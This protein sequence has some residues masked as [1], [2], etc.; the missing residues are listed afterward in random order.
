VLIEGLFDGEI[1]A[2]ETVLVER[3]SQAQGQFQANNVIVSGSFDGQV[4]CQNRFRVT[5]TGR[6]KGEVNTSILVVEEGSTVNCRFVMSREG[7]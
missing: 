6:I 5:P 3:E 7:R 2:K 4:V 1:K